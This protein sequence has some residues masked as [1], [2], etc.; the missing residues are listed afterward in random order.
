M[1]RFRI[2]IAVFCLTLS[3]PLAFFVWRT[4]RGL[5][6]EETATLQFFATTLFDEVESALADIVRREESRAIDDYVSGKLTPDGFKDRDRP[7]SDAA[8]G[9][10]DADYILGYFQNN[11]DG[12]FQSPLAETEFDKGAG[13][14]VIVDELR[15]ANRVFNTKRVV[16]TD[17]IAPPA[18]VA[19]KKVK[20]QPRASL[21]DRYL[22]TSRLQR[23]KPALE[24]ASSIGAA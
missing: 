19:K 5:E 1:N 12:S 11:P 6:Q 16:A 21:A 23:S 3:I 2:L 14:R 8:G 9:H 17:L 24:K 13:G 10:E 22:D 7:K 4:Y 20:E 18:T 15:R